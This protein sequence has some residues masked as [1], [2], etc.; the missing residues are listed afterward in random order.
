MEDVIRRK[1]DKF[2][3]QKA[4]FTEY[5]ADFPAGTP[6]ANVAAVNAAI[7]AEMN[8]LAGDQF[9]GD[10]SMRQ[11]TSDK[12]ELLDDL[13]ILLRNINRAANAF[14]DEIPGTDQMFRLPRNRSEDNLLATARSFHED[15]TPFKDQFIEYGLEADFLE[16]LEE[17]VTDI[18]AANLRGD[19]SG[20]QRAGSTGGLTDAAKR[21]MANSRRADSLVRIKFA[22][23][24]QALA[25]W[26]V[27]SHLERAPK[28]A[29]KTEE[30]DEG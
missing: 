30:K 18:E 25:A 11:A 16:E 23:N 28:K 22:R 6:G 14:E 7:V 10:G 3:R 20:E 15:A 27:A 29:K 21:G 8:E 1:L 17:F 2:D 26:T 19:T 4:F 12:D 9:S 5:A 13:S 24:P